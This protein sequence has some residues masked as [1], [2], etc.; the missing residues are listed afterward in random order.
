MAV[1]ASDGEVSWIATFRYANG[2]DTTVRIELRNAGG[3]GAP[4]AVRQ[5]D[6]QLSDAPTQ[7]WATAGV[8]AAALVV[9][10]ES[11]ENAALETKPE[12]K[13]EP[14]APKPAP[15][16]A[17]LPEHRAQPTRGTEVR[18]DLAALAGPG[19]DRGPWRVGGQ[20]RASLAWSAF[21][22]F[23]WAA[24]AG[25]GR[26]GDVSAMWWSGAAGAGIRFPLGV[27]PLVLDGRMGTEATWVRLSTGNGQNGAHAWRTRWGG[28]AAVD[29][30]LVASRHVHTVVSF[31]ATATWPRVVVNARDERIGSEPIVR[32]ALLGGL[33]LVP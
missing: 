13:P 23:P 22:L 10:V 29:L 9:G 18:L 7:R 2:P 20:L 19:F 6:F 25:S 1:D 4:V 31:E 12:P 15:R 11:A 3:A 27:E 14:P 5:L 17:R 16:L 8:V 26:K 24:A 21:P 32:W 28:V 33:R 30:V